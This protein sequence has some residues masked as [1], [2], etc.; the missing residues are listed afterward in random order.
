MKHFFQGLVLGA[1]VMYG[2]VNYGANHFGAIQEWFGGAKKSFRHDHM[3]DE[4]DRMIH[5]FLW[6]H[7]V[8][9]WQDEEVGRG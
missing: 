2:Y 6:R 5:G 8:D 4:A 1:V 9:R 3:R 7:G